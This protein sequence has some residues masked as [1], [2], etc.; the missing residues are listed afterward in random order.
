MTSSAVGLLAVLFGIIGFLAQLAIL[1]AIGFG[2]VWKD[3]FDALITSKVGLL[4]SAFFLG[5]L[6]GPLLHPIKLSRFEAGL[7]G[8]LIGWTSLFIQTLSGSS[9]GY[10]ANRIS[11]L[12]AFGNYIVKPMFWVMLLGSI[13]AAAL[14]VAF[15]NWVWLTNEDKA[16]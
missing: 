13:P 3:F 7:I 6:F 5:Y 1:L 12:H 16:L 8:A 10:F 4:V 15:G 9:V 11:D 14:G 2:S